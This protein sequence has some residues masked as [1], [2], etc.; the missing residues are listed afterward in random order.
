MT[1]GDLASQARINISQKSRAT[2]AH[3]GLWKLTVTQGVMLRL[4]L[5]R[6]AS[7]HRCCGL[8]TLLGAEEHKEPVRLHVLFRN[9][10]AVSS[11]R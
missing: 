4:M 10:E 7:S 1:Q 6:S 5:A 9:T 3:Q 11:A 2:C 8:P